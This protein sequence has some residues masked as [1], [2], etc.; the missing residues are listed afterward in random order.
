VV[1]IV[2][3]ALLSNSEDVADVN[4]KIEVSSADE[5]ARKIKAEQSRKERDEAKKKREIVK[6]EREE[7]K[8]IKAEQEREERQE[9]EAQAKAEAEAEEEA[10][11][12]TRAE[13][14]DEERKSIETLWI[15]TSKALYSELAEVEFDEDSKTLY[16]TPND[17]FMDEILAYKLGTAPIEKWEELVDAFASFNK[18]KSE[19][20]GLGYSI[21]ILN[22]GDTDRTLLLVKDGHVKIDF[23]AE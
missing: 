20:L 23:L 10:L 19:S 9:A 17:G 18:N 21:A 16:F 3:G 6:E 5:E 14:T 12:K 8:R 15:E 4:S 13:Y 1:V 11:A 7:A 22:P 2:V